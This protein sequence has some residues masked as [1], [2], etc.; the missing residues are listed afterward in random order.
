MHTVFPG[1]EKLKKR[2]M[3]Q[4]WKEMIINWI[5][6]ILGMKPR[7]SSNKEEDEWEK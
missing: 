7:E 3:R 6:K 5:R 1:E 2:L 4:M